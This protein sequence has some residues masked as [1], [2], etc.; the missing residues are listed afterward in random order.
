M[1]M[2]TVAC[3][4]THRLGHEG[5]RLASLCGG[6]F[7]DILDYHGIVSHFSHFAKLDLYLKLAAAADLMVMILHAD[8]HILK[9]KAHTGAQVAGYIMWLI[10]VITALMRGL[11]AVVVKRIAAVP[12]SLLSINAV[13]HAVRQSL[14]AHIV[15]NMELKLRPYHHLVRNA[16]LFHIFNCALG[17]IPRVLVKRP[18]VRTVYYHNIAGHCKRRNSRK[19]I[20]CCSSKVGNKHHIAVFNGSIAI[21]AAVKA[22]AVYQSIL[23]Q[24][25]LRNKYMAPAA[26]NVSHLKIDHLNVVSFDEFFYIIKVRKHNCLLFIHSAP[27]RR[28]NVHKNMLCVKQLAL[29]L[30]YRYITSA[31]VVSISS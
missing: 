1:N 21:I 16:C 6:V 12:I 13:A 4:V 28:Q 14:V 27:W 30:T 15:K 11:V 17:N 20:K 26:V 8:A 24:S 7:D 2:H 22:N 5:S 19:R 9:H 10:Y 31:C 18:V 3:L 25:L 23:V 29:F